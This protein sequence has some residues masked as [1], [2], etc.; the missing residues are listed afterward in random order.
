MNA[1][2]TRNWIAA[3][4]AFVGIHCATDTLYQYAPYQAM[5]GGAFDGHPWHEKVGIQVLDPNTPATQHLG[6]KFEVADEIYQFKHFV[7]EPLRLL[8]ALDDAS[9]DA[10]KVP[11]GSGVPSQCG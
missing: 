4:H 3:G 9:I 6:A 11:M 1:A 10:S 7:R 2:S 5:V 8:L